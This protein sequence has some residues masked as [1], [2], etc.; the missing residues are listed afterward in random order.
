MSE[1]AVNNLVNDVGYFSKINGFI[2][3]VQP[4]DNGLSKAL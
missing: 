1:F 3:S 4:S 2:F